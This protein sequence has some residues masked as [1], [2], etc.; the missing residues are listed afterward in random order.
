M[1]SSIHIGSSGPIYWAAYIPKDITRDTRSGVDVA[2]FGYYAGVE[3][4]RLKGLKFSTSFDEVFKGTHYLVC[5]GDV[6]VTVEPDAYPDI[7]R[8]LL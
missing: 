6:M 7:E 2:S 8:R 4:C 1:S 3:Y 5:C